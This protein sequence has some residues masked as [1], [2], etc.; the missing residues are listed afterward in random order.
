MIKLKSKLLIQFLAT[1]CFALSCKAPFE[2][3][4]TIHFDSDG[5]IIDKIHYEIIVSEREKVLRLKLRNGYNS[6]ANIWRDP[7]KLRKK[8]IFQWR[9]LRSLYSPDSLPMNIKTSPPK[10][11]T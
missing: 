1:I 5:N 4:D 9:S 10:T 2:L 8:R 11:N 3:S 6:G 7:I